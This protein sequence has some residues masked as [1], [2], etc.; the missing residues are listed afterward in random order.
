MFG[1]AICSVL[2]WFLR[3]K[4]GVLVVCS[5]LIRCAGCIVAAC[6]RCWLTLRLVIGGFWCFTNGWG[7]AFRLRG[8]LCWS[9]SCERLVGCGCCWCGD[10]VFGG[11]WCFW[12]VGDLVCGGGYWECGGIDCCVG[13]LVD[14]GGY[15][16]LGDV[17]AVGDWGVC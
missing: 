9:V 11:G 17:H 4:G 16:G 10:R 7:S 8:S 3:L 5:W 2:L 15:W 1:V 12:F 6:V 14:W 13:Y